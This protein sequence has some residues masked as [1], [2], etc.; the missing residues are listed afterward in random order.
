[1]EDAIKATKELNE[2]GAGARVI[3]FCEKRTKDTMQRYRK[4]ELTAVGITIDRFELEYLG[5][6]IKTLWK[7]FW[8]G[9]LSF[10]QCRAINRCNHTHIKAYDPN[11]ITSY[12]A[13]ATKI[14]TASAAIDVEKADRK[15]DLQ[16]A[17]FTMLSAFSVGVMFSSVILSF[18]A[19]IVFLA[20]VKIITIGINIGMKA[21]R[22][23]DLSLMEIQR[24][25]LRVSETK[26]C[27]EWIDKNPV[28]KNNEHSYFSK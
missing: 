17:I 15:N 11:F 25:K 22:G 14:Q 28:E 13:A 26:A 5:K 6:G 16:S 7:D 20:I 18:S 21:T 27:I 1:M 2:K 8:A 24:N 12:Y 23:W 9:K 3:E 19:Q 10:L 4:N